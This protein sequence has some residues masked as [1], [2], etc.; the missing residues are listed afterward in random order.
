[1]GGIRWDRPWDWP[2]LGRQRKRNVYDGKDVMVFDIPTSAPSAT[3]RYLPTYLSALV[4]E[5]ERKKHQKLSAGVAML[6]RKCEISRLLSCRSLSVPSGSTGTS[7]QQDN[8]PP[9]Q[10]FMRRTSDQSMRWT[11][12]FLAWTG[13]RYQGP[14]CL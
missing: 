10:Q 5:P 3:L 13:S 11:M 2:E 14:T 4:V 6:V 7:Y 8:V 12:R 1:M 9:K